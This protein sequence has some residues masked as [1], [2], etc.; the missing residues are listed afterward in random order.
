MPRSCCVLPKFPLNSNRRRPKAL[1]LIQLLGSRCPWCPEIFLGRVLFHGMVKIVWCEVRWIRW[2]AE[3]HQSAYTWNCSKRL[4]ADLR[5]FPSS[6]I[7]SR[8]S[9][10]V[11]QSP[12]HEQWQ[13]FP[14]FEQLTSAHCLTTFKVLTPSPTSSFKSVRKVLT[15]HGLIC[16]NTFTNFVFCSYFHD[17]HTVYFRS[18]TALKD[19]S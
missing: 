19:A 5:F 13:L 11:L 3:L 17:L 7:F 8:P 12:L 1:H 9:L 2:L 18:M 16:L 4:D 10:G 14:N 6:R 15:S